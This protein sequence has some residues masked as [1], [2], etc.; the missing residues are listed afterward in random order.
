MRRHRRPRSLPQ[1]G[2]MTQRGQWV[3]QPRHLQRKRIKYKC[4]FHIGQY[5]LVLNK[6]TTGNK[7]PHPEKNYGNSTS[8]IKSTAI[9]ILI[10]G[11]IGGTLPSAILLQQYCCILLQCFRYLLPGFEHP[12]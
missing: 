11:T 8:D 12:K 3:G 6:H 7:S 4:D 9:Q 2:G 5:S 10:S 1:T